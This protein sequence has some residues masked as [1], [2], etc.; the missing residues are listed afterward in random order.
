M[1]KTYV[2]MLFAVLT[3][4]SAF[5]E[6]YEKHTCNMLFQ[7]LNDFLNLAQKSANAV[8]LML[9]AVKAL[10]YGS[11]TWEVGLMH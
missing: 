8:D 3:I 10:G 5:G 11:G 6:E 1:Y 2:S 4:I 7:G 9:D